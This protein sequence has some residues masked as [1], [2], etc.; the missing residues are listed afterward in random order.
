M[1]NHAMAIHLKQSMTNFD[2]YR[3]PDVDPHP[4]VEN[5]GVDVPESDA[6]IA[7]VADPLQSIWDADE[8]ELTVPVDAEIDEE[9]LYTD[10]F[11]RAN[12]NASR[13]L[14]LGFLAIALLGTTLA[15][16]FVLSQKPPKPVQPSPSDPLQVP[17][18]PGIQPGIEQPN[19]D[20]PQPP[21]GVPQNP[22]TSF[23]GTA[24]I[25]NSSGV[26][27]QTPATG[28]PSQSIPSD[29]GVVQPQGSPVI[30]PGGGTPPP[31]PPS[32]VSDGQQ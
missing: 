20:L 5:D 4:P 9:R 27:G 3:K 16:W 18:P 26:P 23:P 7:S 19:L 14:F 13:S 15:A 25:P 31:P 2:P 8:P 29:R 30:V 12:E 21:V 11:I 22:G 10:A 24:P 17:Q 6:E 28:V 1:G 32:G